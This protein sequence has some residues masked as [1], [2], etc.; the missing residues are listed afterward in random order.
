MSERK[1]RRE[2][3]VLIWQAMRTVEGIF[4][5]EC[6]KHR[7]RM[8]TVVPVKNILLVKG[9]AI[10]GVYNRKL[11][12][13]CINES[14]FRKLMEELPKKRVLEI[15]VIVLLHELK[16][17]I[18]MSTAEIYWTRRYEEETTKWAIE[19]ARKCKVEGEFL[20]KYLYS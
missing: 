12:T 19:M 14:Y 4:R 8:P 7:I 16:H 6:R 9:K 15:L 2:V 1:A 17:H 5:E 13:I 11:N 18:D 3:V 10:A 20:E